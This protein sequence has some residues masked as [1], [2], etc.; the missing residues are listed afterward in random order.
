MS[1]YKQRMKIHKLRDDIKELKRIM[2]VPRLHSKYV[3]DS[4][5]YYKK[6]NEGQ[7]LTQRELDLYDLS[8]NRSTPLH[9]NHQSM[10]QNLNDKSR[11]SLPI[12]PDDLAGMDNSEEDEDDTFLHSRLDFIPGNLFNPKSSLE[13]HNDLVHELKG[14]RNKPSIL[15]HYK[16]VASLAK[17]EL[18]KPNNGLLTER[19]SNS[20][21]SSIEQNLAASTNFSDRTS[22][23]I[24]PRNVFEK[25]LHFPKTVKQKELF[26][27]KKKHNQSLPQLA[28]IPNEDISNVT[29]AREKRSILSKN[30]YKSPEKE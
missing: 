16:S 20:K 5:S 29:K 17:K 6:K 22:N 18:S 28:R 2:L 3:E 13:R 19:K 9:K 23:K 8:S 10:S 14:S 27:K 26:G 30:R 7:Y 21:L 24:L 15:G 25:K 4:K 12:S 11:F 1:R